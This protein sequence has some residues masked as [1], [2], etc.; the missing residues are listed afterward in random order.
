MFMEE[1]HQEILKILEKEGRIKASEIQTRF[2]V[3]FDTARRDLRILEE[4]GL[5]KRT[6]GGAIPALQR[7]YTTP[8]NYTPRDI[9]EI[10]DNYFAIAKK[11]IGYIKAND[12]VFLTAA[13]VGYFMAKNLPQEFPFTVVTNSI[14]IA[15]ELRSYDNIT[16]IMVGGELSQKGQCSDSFAAEFV[17]NIRFDISFLTSAGFSA[18]FG[19]S[20]QKSKGVS[21]LQAVIG[22]SK[23]NM[24]LY[25]TEKIGVE[26]ILKVCS[27]DTFDK[28]IT[29]W[30]APEDELVKIEEL[31]VE[32]IVVKEKL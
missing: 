15:D 16:T 11:A 31:G 27:A 18:S 4:K 28:L 6:H 22:S 25:P 10:K 2:N 19:M 12:V 21:F 3:G 26:S 7:G 24:A 8:P 23:C 17:K 5:L 30:D 1:R 13:S 32:V 9:T 20:I 29:D 14:I